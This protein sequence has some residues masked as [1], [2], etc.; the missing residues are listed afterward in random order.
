MPMEAYQE[1]VIEEK[2][3]LDEKIVRLSSFIRDRRKMV[4]VFFPEQMRLMSQLTIMRAY[5]SVLEDR[6]A[7]FNDFPMQDP[8]GA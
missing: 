1:R 6:I 4:P 7:C 8:E 2:R 3:E 5:S